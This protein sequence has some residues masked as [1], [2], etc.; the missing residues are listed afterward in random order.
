MTHSDGRADR[1]SEEAQATTVDYEH[2]AVDPNEASRAFE[3][4]DER[5]DSV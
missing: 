3:R 5:T 4:G 1:P 2:P